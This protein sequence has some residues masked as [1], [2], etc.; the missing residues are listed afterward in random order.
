MNTLDI[1]RNRILNREE[2]N[3]LDLLGGL[4]FGFEIDGQWCDPWQLTEEERLAWMQ[5]VYDAMSDIREEGRLIDF[6]KSWAGLDKEH[7]DHLLDENSGLFARSRIDAMKSMSD[8]DC[9][10]LR[11]AENWQ[12][13]DFLTDNGPG[14]APRMP[15]D[16]DM[17]ASRG[18][19]MRAPAPT[20]A[21]AA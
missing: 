6:T 21:M 8:A 14:F 7:R 15:V 13:A 16:G 17:F 12:V 2:E 20:M 3:A 18:A 5:Q 10:W 9:A 1:V 19:E 11:G 4:R